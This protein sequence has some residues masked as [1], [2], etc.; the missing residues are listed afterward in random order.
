MSREHF[1]ASGRLYKCPNPLHR[2]SIGRLVGAVQWAKE[3]WCH[4]KDNGNLMTV[5]LGVS[6]IEAPDGL[7]IVEVV[8]WRLAVVIGWRAP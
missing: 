2:F 4:M 3:S 7:W 8:L 1:E 5:W 6:R